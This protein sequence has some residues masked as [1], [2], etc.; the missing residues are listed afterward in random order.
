MPI[1]KKDGTG[2]TVIYDI[3]GDLKDKSP[4]E[5]VLL[6]HL[7]L[8]YVLNGILEA[9]FC[10]DSNRKRGQWIE[11]ERNINSFNKINI[12]RKVN[13]I[14]TE[15]AKSLHA[16]RETR[17]QIGH[18]LVTTNAKYKEKPIEDSIVLEGF[19]GDTINLW[20]KLHNEVLIKILNDPKYTT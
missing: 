20:T 9:Y 12:L 2:T 15:T 14:D 5:T 4:R 19:K 7:Y 3:V 8:E 16:I 13:I 6:G 11:I 18:E 1:V 17:N 10:A